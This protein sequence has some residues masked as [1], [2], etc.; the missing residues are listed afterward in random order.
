[1]KIYEINEQLRQLLETNNE[2]GLIE[3]ETFDQIIAFQADRGEKLEWLGLHV[4]ELRA[5]AQAIKAE[6][7]VLYKRATSA[8]K[9]ADGIENYLT[10]VMTDAQLDKFQTNRLALS[11]RNSKAVE[12]V[13]EAL[14][15]KDYFR[16]KREP[17]KV[18]L[19][20][21]LKDGKDIPGATLVERRRLQVK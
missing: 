15:P 12:I 2:D 6:A 11:F 18:A 9:R 4:K 16:I 19:S 21:D 20:A 7:D 13:S 14:I 17:D 3:S 10:F 5:E 8:N 1:M